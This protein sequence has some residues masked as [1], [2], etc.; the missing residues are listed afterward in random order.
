[1]DQIPEGSAH[2]AGHFLKGGRENMEGKE[3]P[4]KEQLRAQVKDLAQSRGWPA[5]QLAHFWPSVVGGVVPGFVVGNGIILLLTR[6][7]F[8][9][10]WRLLCGEG[11]GVGVIIVAVTTVI[12]IVVGLTNASKTTADEQQWTEWLSQEKLSND[13]MLRAKILLEQK[14]EAK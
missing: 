6:G 14:P 12:G 4:A 11:G 8:E 10:H 2:G 5:L 7:N 3:L 13:D 9:G 1:V